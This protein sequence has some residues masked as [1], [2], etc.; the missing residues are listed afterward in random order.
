MNCVYVFMTN[1]GTST[2]WFYPMLFIIFYQPTQKILNR[3]PT[4]KKS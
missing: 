2:Q 1:L 4:V 3:C